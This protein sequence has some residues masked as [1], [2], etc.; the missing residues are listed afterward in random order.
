MVITNSHTEL[1]SMHTSKDSC[2]SH[3]SIVNK[4][5]APISAALRYQYPCC[6]KK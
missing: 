6:T 5:A 3:A 1:E 2:I 4:K